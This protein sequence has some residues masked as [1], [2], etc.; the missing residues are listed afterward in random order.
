MSPLLPGTPRQGQGRLQAQ[1]SLLS[2]RRWFAFVT[3]GLAAIPIA[4]RRVRT[5]R[6]RGE[7]GPTGWFGHC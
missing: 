7:P 1:P 5:R 3:A 6:R 4:L 2:R